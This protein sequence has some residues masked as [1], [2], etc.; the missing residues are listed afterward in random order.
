M[1]VIS[2]HSTVKIICIPFGLRNSPATFNRALQDILGDLP[3]V[4]VE[5]DVA[6]GGRDMLEHDNNLL[7]FLKPSFRCKS[8]TING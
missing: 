3:S 7:T 5:V 2:Q 8:I 1:N 6:C 4:V